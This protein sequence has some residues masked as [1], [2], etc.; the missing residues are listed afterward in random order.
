[1]K[2]ARDSGFE[3]GRR[4]AS[5]TNKLEVV[6]ATVEGKI[7]KQGDLPLIPFTKHDEYVVISTEL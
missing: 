4:E 1:L 6:V 2:I 3:F 5:T 7:M